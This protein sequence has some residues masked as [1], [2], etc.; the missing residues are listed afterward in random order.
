MVT[1]AKMEYVI[2]LVIITAGMW[3]YYNRR[4][5]ASTRKELENQVKAD[6]KD[7]KE[8]LDKVIA[9]AQE[10]VKKR[11]PRKKKTDNE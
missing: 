2:A 10:E 9:K 8:D 7:V 5:K 3:W 1:E 4:L 6:V 11:A